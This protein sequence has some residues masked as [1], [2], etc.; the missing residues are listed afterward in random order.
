M[1]APRPLLR[2]AGT[3]APDGW[4]APGC[5]CASCA[6]AAAA[7]R[8]PL[9][10]HVGAA[11][12]PDHALA[13]GSERVVDGV[14]VARPAP[15]AWEAT[16]P[17]G[18][19]LLLATADE[20]PPAS[21]PAYEVVLL[22]DA[23][24]GLLAALRRSGAVSPSTQV[25]AVGLSHRHRPGDELERE[26]AAMGVRALPDGA[27]LDL[28]APA[29]V[30]APPRRTLVLGGARSGKSAVAERL[31][32]AE[33]AV[34]YVATAAPRADDPEWDARVATHRARRPAEWRTEETYDLEPLL[35]AD[36]PPLL[37]DCLSLWL[38]GVLDECGAWDDGPDAL[39][40]VRRR[41]DALA[42]AWR[43]T[44][45]RVVAVSSE[46]GSGVVPGT[47]SGRLFRD[48][49]GRLNAA[50]A[51]ESEQALHVVA[52]RVACL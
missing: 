45:R 43:G 5:P 33:P 1:T 30:P 50:I 37:V 12:L 13:V 15:G 7:P 47:P 36:G 26:L 8:L 48:E 14:R 46:V 35:A 23:D 44:S 51:A 24:A 22:G 2:L 21:R 6:L 19:R 3:G 11:R 18:A 34:T 10:V 16:L 31:L 41:V 52:G 49:L 38:T 20:V 28:D 29:A 32:A 27:L 9:D 25:V 17:D 4:P 40:R 39:P 42:A